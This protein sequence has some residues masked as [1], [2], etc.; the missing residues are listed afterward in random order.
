MAL[1]E[2]VDGQWAIETSDA[3]RYYYADPAD[4]VETISCLDRLKTGGFVLLTGARASGK[5]T[6]LHRLM[7]Q[8]EDDKY[9]CV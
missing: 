4:Q 1:R 7:V 9:P 5:T 3:G 6:R 8:L 2:E